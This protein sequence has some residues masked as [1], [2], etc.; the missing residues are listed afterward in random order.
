MN[1]YYQVSESRNAKLTE[2]L[3]YNNISFQDWDEWDFSKGKNRLK[4]PQ[5]KFLWIL[6]Y[7]ILE[8]ADQELLRNDLKDCDGILYIVQEMDNGVYYSILKD[9]LDSLECEMY[10]HLDGPLNVTDDRAVTEYAFRFAEIIDQPRLKN[11]QIRNKDFLLLT[12]LRK[13]RPHRK[14]VVELLQQNSLLEN[15]IGNITDA[16]KDDVVA[17][18]KIID[19][20]NH[21]DQNVSGKI[22]LVENHI[23]Y[24]GT[25][26]GIG[27]GATTQEGVTTPAYGI[28]WDLYNQAC[29]ELVLESTWHS[30]S[31]FTEKVNRPLIAEIPFVVCSDPGYYNALHFYGFETFNNSIDESFADEPNLDLRIKKMV[32]AM[33]DCDPKHLY[34]DNIE[35]CKHNFDNLCVQLHRQRFKFYHDLD[36]FFEKIGLTK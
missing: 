33:T 12:I 30:H 29:Y 9:Y 19:Q 11:Q 17:H 14:K 21:E 5:G 18:R 1:V 22:P 3:L 31:Y 32:Q 20:R 26:K 23:G 10:F 28:A 2:H 8:Q 25:V 36:V 7:N 35:K 15:F 27:L 34:E 24:R 16:H 13:D 6:P 4:V